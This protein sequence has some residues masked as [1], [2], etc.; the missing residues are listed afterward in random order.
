[1]QPG[2]WVHPSP[3]KTSLIG[4]IWSNQI[5]VSAHTGQ[6]PCKTSCHYLSHITYLWL[7]QYPIWFRQWLPL[8][9]PRYLTLSG[10]NRLFAFGT[11]S[12]WFS[13]QLISL[14]RFHN[15][16]PYY[17][18]QIRCFVV[19]HPTQLSRLK[20]SLDC[21]KICRRRSRHVICENRPPM[22]HCS[23]PTGYVRLCT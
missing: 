8:R 5:Y 9:K 13:C 3:S 19:T 20:A 14:R 1:M 22:I 12:L 10:I 7:N 11:V 6:S 4:S 16:L 17:S 15:Y 18:C 23:F 21:R 2:N